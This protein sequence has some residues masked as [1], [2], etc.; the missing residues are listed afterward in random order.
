M[1]S[2]G[3]PGVH[4]RS[5]ERVVSFDRAL[6]SL[7]DI[8]KNYPRLKHIIGHCPTG[9]VMAKMP[10]SQETAKMLIEDSEIA[11]DIE[12]IAPFVGSED[13]YLNIANNGRQ[14]ELPVA[15]DA[16]MYAT[17]TYIHERTMPVERMRGLYDRGF[18]FINNLEDDGVREQVFQLWSTTFGW[19]HDELDGLRDRLR[20]NSHLSADE[21]LMW[22]TFLVDRQGTLVSAAMAEGIEL[23]GKLL[24]EATEWNTEEQHR[25]K[26]L[27]TAAVMAT[28]AQVLA[29]IYGRESFLPFLVYAEC[30]FL[31]RADFLGYG[32]GFEIPNRNI[33]SGRRTPQ[34]L[35]ANVEVDGTLSTFT[36]MSLTGNSITQYYQ[37]DDTARMVDLIERSRR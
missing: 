29:D 30:N 7:Q 6:V 8:Q 27:G 12:V 24:V 35:S 19:K 33:F 37:P 15:R 1:T 22:A 36:F 14:R 26:G 32:A 5:Y 11:N 23:D 4:R 16:V 3:K 13:M 31:T 21:R 28:N 34:V 25:G 2:T 9:R 10:I 18:R 20:I 17:D